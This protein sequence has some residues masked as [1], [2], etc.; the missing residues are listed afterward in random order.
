M[1]KHIGSVGVIE[2][3][4]PLGRGKTRALPV[5]APSGSVQ[6]VNQSGGRG[7]LTPD[8]LALEG[9]PPTRPESYR[10]SRLSLRCPNRRRPT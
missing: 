2:E 10:P 7:A 6:R 8:P 9:E 4:A 5:T 3:R 1:K